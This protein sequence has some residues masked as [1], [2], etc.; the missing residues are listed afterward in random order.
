MKSVNIASVQSVR[1]SIRKPS[2]TEFLM[3]VIVF[4]PFLFGLL[5][6]LMR[7][8]RSIRYLLDVAWVVLL[9]YLIGFSRKLSCRGTSKLMA[10]VILFFLYTLM[11]SIVQIQ[12]LWYYVWGFRNNFRLYTA[13]FAFVLLLNPQN[14]ENYIRRFDG[15]FWIHV[16]VSLIQ[17]FFF[18]IKQD[19]LGG[20]FSV[21]V[22][23]NGYA[24]LFLLIIVAKSAVWY[25]EKREKTFECFAKCAAALFVAALAEMKFFFV[26]FAFVIILAVLYTKF[27]WRKLWLTVGGVAAIF[28]AAAILVRLFPG[29]ADFLSIEW[30]LNT[31]LSDKGYTSSGDINRLTAI[32][33]INEL[34]LHNGWQRMFGLGLGNCDTSGFA[35]LNTPFFE[36]FGDY[37]YTWLSYAM[38]YLETG[39]SG[40]VFYFGFFVLVYRRICKIQKHVQGEAACYCLIGRIV[41]LL[42]MI[43]SVYNSSLRTEAGYMAYFILA[44]PFAFNE[45]DGGDVR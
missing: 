30:F 42:C 19:Q 38:I 35:F 23:G 5:N 14:I 12:S 25:L 33:K 3:W 4:L 37:H 1:Y 26:E 10:W 8:P 29:F 15:L 22:G 31:A 40:L 43:I 34:W 7:F 41:A 18:G 9:M 13:F 39:W 32:T 21:E 36:K 44:I 27:S 20:L 28:A 17:H 6:E 11:G 24:N 45:K 2:Q 16:L